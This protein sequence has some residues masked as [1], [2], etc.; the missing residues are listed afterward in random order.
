MLLRAHG[1]THADLKPENTL[2]NDH[3]RL[4]NNDSSGASVDKKPALPLESSRFYLSRGTRSNALQHNNRS[5]YPGITTRN[6]PHEDL[7][8]I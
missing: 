6:Q 3:L 5:L 7:D 2:L 8:D 1:I 4:R